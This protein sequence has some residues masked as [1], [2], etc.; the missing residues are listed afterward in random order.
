MSRGNA[1]VPTPVPGGCQTIATT[2]ATARTTS[3]VGEQTRQVAI[4][5]TAAAHYRFGGSSVVATTSD[6]YIGAGA[7]HLVRIA[8]SQYVA[9]IRSTADGSVFV[10]EMD[11]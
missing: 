5:A 7:E 9:A 4:T 2:A 3:G 8:P 6:T 1:R 11:G 10:S